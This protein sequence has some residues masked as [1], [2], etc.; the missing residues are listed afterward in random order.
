MGATGVASYLLNP[1]VAYSTA[2]WKGKNWK[3]TLLAY[4]NRGLK[5]G[6]LGELMIQVSTYL[7]YLD[8]LFLQDIHIPLAN[9]T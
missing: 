3:S 8:Y 4:N 2:T 5:H 7:L 1:K 9:K 6:L